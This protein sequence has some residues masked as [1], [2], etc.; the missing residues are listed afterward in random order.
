[1]ESITSTLA[2]IRLLTIMPEDSVKVIRIANSSLR[3][4]VTTIRN[5]N[6][7]WL[8][9]LEYDYGLV[10]A[11]D[12]YKEDWRAIY[13]EL[14]HCG[15]IALLGS[16]NPN[17]VAIAIDSGYDPSMDSNWPIRLTSEKGYFLSVNRLLEDPRVDPSSHDN[18]A[19]V[20]A[21]INDHYEVVV[22][23]LDDPRVDPSARDNAPIQ[24]SSSLGYLAI[25]DRLLQDRR[26]DP[27]ALDNCAVYYAYSNEYIDVVNRLLQD[28]RVTPPILT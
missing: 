12:K 3:D 10:I 17:L 18:H 15:V 24:M 21:C 27:S 20:Q 19:L 16:P 9:K 5:D 26:V 23:L 28:P 22:R 4:S 25:V 8:S 2:L 6:L 13:K 1:M 11:I 7:F 14:T